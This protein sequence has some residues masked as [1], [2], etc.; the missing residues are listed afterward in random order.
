MIT[1]KQSTEFTHS[2]QFNM[3]IRYGNAINQ[4]M[5]N[6]IKQNF[7]PNVEDYDWL[8]KELWHFKCKEYNINFDIWVQ[9]IK[10]DD[11]YWVFSSLNKHA[12]V[13]NFINNLNILINNQ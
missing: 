8:V 3:A 12:Q 5:I 2:S 9:H 6:Y 7:K 13:K 10:S 4:D 11:T 1:F